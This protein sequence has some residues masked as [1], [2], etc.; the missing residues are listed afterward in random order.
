M[1]EQLAAAKLGA[2]FND[3]ESETSSEEEDAGPDIFAAQDDMPLG[4]TADSLQRNES[5]KSEQDFLSRTESLRNEKNPMEQA[6]SV[7]RK[8]SKKGENAETVQRHGSKKIGDAQSR[9]KDTKKH[10]DPLVRTRSSKF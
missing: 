2:Q 5:L 10:P 1:A 4:E 7:Q 8:G 6:G 9:N 3:S